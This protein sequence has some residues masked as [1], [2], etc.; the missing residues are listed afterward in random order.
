MVA[1]KDLTTIDYTSLFIAAF[2]V[3]I[4]LKTIISV[5]EWGINKL[6]LE[7]KWIKARRQEHE[8]L[9][10]TSEGLVELQRKH[11]EDVM[12]SDK[13]DAEIRQDIKNL[14]DM[15]KNL[16]D[17]FI[18]KEIDDMRWEINNFANKIADGRHCNKDSY[19][20]CLKTYHKYEKILREN[21]LENGEVEISIELINESYR[22]K[23][24]NGF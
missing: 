6:G 9:I 16:T 13:N 14:I 7:T 2:T 10:Q 8:L 24:K 3:L 20:H 21:G 23:L 11:S 17:L 4:G 22:E 18:K 15:F 12:R 1:I 19:K 5:L